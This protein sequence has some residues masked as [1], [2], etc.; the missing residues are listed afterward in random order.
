MSPPATNVK[1]SGTDIFGAGSAARDAANDAAPSAAIT[2]VQG[3]VFTQLS[4]EDVLEKP[5]GLARGRRDRTQC[6]ICRSAWDQVPNGTPLPATAARRRARQ[7][8]ARNQL[9]DP[10]R[11]SV[12]TQRIRHRAGTTERDAGTLQRT[13]PA[14]RCCRPAADCSWQEC[15][16]GSS[17]RFLQAVHWVPSCR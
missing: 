8:L 5:E 4:Y 16:R 15:A 11:G 13:S 12:D 1:P 9:P 7:A 6:G 10:D 2:A 14:A 3:R 17:V